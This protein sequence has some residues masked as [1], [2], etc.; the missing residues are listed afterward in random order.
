MSTSASGHLLLSAAVFQLACRSMLKC[1][2]DA[3]HN[4]ADLRSESV[5]RHSQCKDGHQHEYR[6][7]PSSPAHVQRSLRMPVMVRTHCSLG[8]TE[9]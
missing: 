8:H 7:E 1:Y 5:R 2:S 4:H 6:D 3:K 9:A